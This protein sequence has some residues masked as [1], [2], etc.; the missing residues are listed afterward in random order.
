ML[1]KREVFDSV[2][3]DKIKKLEEAYSVNENKSNPTPI[4]V[5]TAKDLAEYVVDVFKVST[6]KQVL[7]KFESLQ[8][9]ESETEG[10]QDLT[11]AIPIDGMNNFRGLNDY[12]SLPDNMVSL[13]LAYDVLAYSDIEYTIIPLIVGFCIAKNIKGLISYNRN[14][15]YISAYPEDDSFN[16]GSIEVGHEYPEVTIIDSNNLILTS[17]RCSYI[18]ASEFQKYYYDITTNSDNTYHVTC[19]VDNIT[20]LIFNVQIPIH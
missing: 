19:Y 15:N 18:T 20:K 4:T 3:K 14:M 17:I 11:Y 7:Q 12:L 16:I 10:S 13:E 6:I 8:N 2:Q 9:N 5:I 1:N